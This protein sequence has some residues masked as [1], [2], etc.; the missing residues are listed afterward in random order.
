MELITDVLKSDS[1]A[2]DRLQNYFRASFSIALTF[3]RQKDIV[4]Y[5]FSGMNEDLQ[6]HVSLSYET[7]VPYLEKLYNDCKK[8]HIIREEIS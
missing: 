5:T 8:D 1:S 2:Y 7:T 4:E 6:K 3:P